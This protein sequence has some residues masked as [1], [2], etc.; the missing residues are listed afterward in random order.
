M[1]LT[2][3]HWIYGLFTLLILI[4]MLLRKGI[5]LPALMGIFAVAA[6]FN[7]SLAEGFTAIFQ[8]NLIAAKELFSIFLI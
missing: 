5:V 6:V 2:L 1:E 3:A 4:T 8:A 7:K